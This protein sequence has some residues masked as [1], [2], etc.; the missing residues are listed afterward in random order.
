MLILT[1]VGSGA[2]LRCTSLKE[3]VLINGLTVIG[4]GMF[5]MSTL[6]SVM[7]PSTV[8][9]IGEDLLLKCCY[10]DDFLLT[11]TN[12]LIKIIIYIIINFYKTI[13]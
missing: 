9:N 8:T 6:K 10:A 5:Y 12:I 4:M 2:F 11:L 3:I 13:Y 1:F 7:I